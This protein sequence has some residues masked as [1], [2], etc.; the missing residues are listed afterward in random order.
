LKGVG[1]LPLRFDFA[2]MENNN[3]KMLIEYDGKQHFEI[4]FDDEKSFTR[5]QIHDKMK[6]DF[7]KEND[8]PLCRIPYTEYERIPDIINNILL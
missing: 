2:I 7:T 1:G 8:I 3:L 6:N 5:T 4:A